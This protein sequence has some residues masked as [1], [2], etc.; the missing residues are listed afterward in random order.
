M[1]KTQLKNWFASAGVR[2]LKTAA[3]AAIGTIGASAVMGDVNWVLVG[4]GALLAAILSI[5]TSV[6]GIPEVDNGASVFKLAKSNE[7]TS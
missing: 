2:A 1:T 5:L 4:S 3:Q 7:E 6:A